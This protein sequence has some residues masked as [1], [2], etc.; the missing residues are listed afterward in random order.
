MIPGDRID[1]YHGYRLDQIVHHRSYINKRQEVRIAGS[2]ISSRIQTK[3]RN[4]KNIHS[5]K[6]SINEDE[7]G[8]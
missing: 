3:V 1:E 7:S 8:M 4:D 2:R 5:H 6:M